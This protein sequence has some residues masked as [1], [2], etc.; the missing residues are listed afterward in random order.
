MNSQPTP[1]DLILVAFMPSPRDLQIARI[2]GWYRI[3]ARTAPRVLSVDYLA[4]Y[5]PASFGKEHKWR[6]EYLAPVRGHELTTRFEIL[7]EEPDHPRAHE[8]YYKIQLGPVQALPRP[9]H[10]GDWKRFTFLYTTGEYL[11]QAETLN[12]LTVH[13]EERNMLWKALRDRAASSQAYQTPE[14]DLDPMVLA[15]LLGIREG[16]EDYEGSEGYDVV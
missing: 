13:S 14:V 6:V 4:F 12:D 10:A 8:E 5:Q 2:L 15:A 3:P 11:A 1:T 9:I 7:K 16:S